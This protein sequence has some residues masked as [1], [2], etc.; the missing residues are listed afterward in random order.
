MAQ[1]YSRAAQEWLAIDDATDRS[2]IAQWFG[3]RFPIDPDHDD[4]APWLALIDLGVWAARVVREPKFR[5]DP[6]KA[7]R[8]ASLGR[9]TM[10]LAPLWR[11][12][13]TGEEAGEWALMLP[14][15]SD[16]YCMT[17]SRT[18]LG[19][20]GFAE[21]IADVLALPADGGPARSMTG[22]TPAVGRFCANDTA[23]L[24]L[25]AGG[26]G[27]IKGY[28]RHAQIAADGTPPHLVERFHV[29]F[30]PPEDL[31][32]LLVEPDAHEWRVSQLSCAI[33]ADVTEV[34]CADSPRLAQHIDAAMRKKERPRPIPKVLCPRAGAA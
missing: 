6:D 31:G 1:G 30:A 8:D 34:V 16:G 11:H 29:P 19:D 22:F 14:V 10:H 26:L 21:E 23:R 25:Y 2:R 17:L 33:P 9:H 5:V 18:A 3:L 4:I 28:L 27:W 12:P 20:E 24:T 7:A 32:V 15:G 13:I